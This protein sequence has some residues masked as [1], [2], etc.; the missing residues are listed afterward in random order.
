MSK[1]S[2]YGTIMDEAFGAYYELFRKK[3]AVSETAAITLEELFDGEKVTMADKQMLRKLVSYCTVRKTGEQKYW[4][5]EARASNPGNVMRR[6]LFI[7]LAA[8][9]LVLVYCSLV[10]NLK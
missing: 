6:Q 5:D 10:G 7:A 2:Q 3:G 8:L 4:L 9:V 1:K